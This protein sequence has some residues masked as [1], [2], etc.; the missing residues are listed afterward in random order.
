MHTIRA[1]HD[2]DHAERQLAEVLLPAQQPVHGHER[3][4]ESAGS[5]KELAVLDTGPSKTC[6]V[7]TSCSGRA[8]I[9][10]CGR[11]SSRRTR[12][13]QD[14]V[15]SLLERRDGLLPPH[16]G[17]LTQKLIQ[18]VTA[19]EVVEERL[20]GHA[21]ADKDGRPAQDLGVAVHHRGFR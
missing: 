5:T 21:S 10:S 16:R 9:R 8:A 3:I 6:T 14:A 11:F 17:E 12:T 15:A 2:E 19:F 1:R 18:G 13:G 20:D 7:R 4:D